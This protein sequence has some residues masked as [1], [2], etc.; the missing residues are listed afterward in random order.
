M[1]K[2]FSGKIVVGLQGKIGK[3][4]DINE[5]HEKEKD[6]TGNVSRWSNK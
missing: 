5:T 1:K 2:V 4:E 6:D 3:D